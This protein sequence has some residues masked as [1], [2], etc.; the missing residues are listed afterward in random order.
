M[1]PALWY[2]FGDGEVVAAPSGYFGGFYFAPRYY[3]TNYFDRETIASSRTPLLLVASV[4][5]ADARID[6]DRTTVGGSLLDP[7][8][9]TVEA[10]AL[11]P[12]Q[13][14]VQDY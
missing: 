3:D 2:F 14:T 4:F 10:A 8:R 6:P 9:T 7:R 12:D 1:D 11:D 5:I 13:T